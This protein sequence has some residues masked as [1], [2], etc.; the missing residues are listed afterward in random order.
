MFEPRFY[1]LEAV[2]NE[3]GKAF[4]DAIKRLTEE[5]EGVA[6]GN[7]LDTYDYEVVKE[8]GHYTVY[9]THTDY[10]QY[11]DKGTTPHWAPIQPLKDWVEAK[12]SRGLLPQ[13]EGLP[14]MVQWKIARDGTEG[15]EVFGRAA[16]EVIPKFEDRWNDALAKD[17]MENYLNGDDINEWNIL[18]I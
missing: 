8:N 4:V 7:M 14:Y 9:L 15:R 11:F 3:F 12:Q 2:L 10:F 6:S 5:A 16:Q 18:K 13:I 1:N 17:F